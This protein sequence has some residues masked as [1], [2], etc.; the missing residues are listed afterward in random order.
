MTTMGVYMS[1]ALVNQQQTTINTEWAAEFADYRKED[2]KA[3]FTPRGLKMFHRKLRQWDSATQERLI[4]HAME[5]G[6]KT[7]FWVEP[8][9]QQGTSTKSTT[10]QED[11]TDTSW[12]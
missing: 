3:A 9:K 5:A 4:A 2:K 10:L 7:V 8:P 1:L 12:A 11:L 6:W